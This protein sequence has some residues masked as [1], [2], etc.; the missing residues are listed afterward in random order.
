MPAV[1]NQV[2]TEFLKLLNEELQM[3]GARA[4][5]VAKDIGKPRSGRLLRNLAMVMPW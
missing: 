1:T 3:V 2:R 5:T 4:D